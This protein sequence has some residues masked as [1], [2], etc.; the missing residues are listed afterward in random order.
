MFLVELWWNRSKS[1]TY[2][3]P[4]MGLCARIRRGVYVNVCACICVNHETKTKMA[5]FRKGILR[6]LVLQ[7]SKES[8]FDYSEFQTTI[9]FS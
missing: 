6:W 4:L 1:S 3:L 2:Q 5:W 7:F 8:L 9:P